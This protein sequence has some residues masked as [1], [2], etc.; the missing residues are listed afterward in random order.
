MYYLAAQAL[1]ILQQDL[2]KRVE[3]SILFPPHLSPAHIRSALA[4]YEEDIETAGKRAVCSCSRRLL[5]ITDIHELEKQ[6]VT[7]RLLRGKLDLCG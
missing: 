5:L 7:R 2:D 6:D 3:A 1:T 4:R